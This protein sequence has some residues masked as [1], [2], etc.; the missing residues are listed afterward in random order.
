MTTQ[1]ITP[2][3]MTLLNIDLVCRGFSV[4]YYIGEAVDYIPEGWSGG[5]LG[6]TNVQ[7]VLSR[8]MKQF[9]YSYGIQAPPDLWA[10]VATVIRGAERIARASSLLEYTLT[11]T[12]D[13]C[14]ALYAR[15]L[16]LWEGLQTLE[17]FQPERESIYRLMGFAGCN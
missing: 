12:C 7:A 11:R 15:D 1:L 13:N 17:V 2:E 5:P 14:G 3:N 9:T 8:G 6:V 10:V 4:S 16:A